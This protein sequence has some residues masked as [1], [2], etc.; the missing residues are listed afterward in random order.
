MGQHG[1]H[2][3][4]MLAAWSLLLG[5][6]PMAIHLSIRHFPKG[7]RWIGLLLQYNLYSLPRVTCADYISCHGTLDVNTFWNKI[8]DPPQVGWIRTLTNFDLLYRFRVC[9]DWNFMR[10]QQHI[11]FFHLESHIYMYIYMYIYIYMGYENT[12]YW[13]RLTIYLRGKN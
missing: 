2:L 6:A 11:V 13:V 9:T 12:K 5:K 3:G 10:F 4:L 1:A 7:H 8:M